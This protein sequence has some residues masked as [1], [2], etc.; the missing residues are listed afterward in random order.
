MERAYSHCILIQE[1][2]TANHDVTVR[3]TMTRGEFVAA[4]WLA[5][6]RQA[7]TIFMFLVALINFGLGMVFGLGT[8]ISLGIGLLL[9]IALLP[10]V[11]SV[12]QYRPHKAVASEQVHIFQDA[13]IHVSSSKA[14]SKLAWSFYST[15]LDVGRFYFFRC[16]RRVCNIIPKRAFQDAMD[17]E[18]FRTLCRANIKVNF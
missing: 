13:D 16:G 1:E 17:E 9:L 14:A 11:Q 8:N 18:N 6:V 2:K 3:F 7:S 12:V 15:V 10:F 4:A 5:L